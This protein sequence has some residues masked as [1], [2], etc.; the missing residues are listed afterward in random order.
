[1]TMIALK[2]AEKEK[3]VILKIRKASDITKS[4]SIQKITNKRYSKELGRWIDKWGEL[5]NLKIKVHAEKNLQGEDKARTEKLKEAVGFKA[6]LVE[7]EE[8]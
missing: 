3:T 2:I 8:V 7:L 6:G 5:G 4:C 1:M